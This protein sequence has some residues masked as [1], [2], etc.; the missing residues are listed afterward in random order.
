MN[1]DHQSTSQPSLERGESVEGVIRRVF[2][3]PRVV[4]QAALEDFAAQLCVLV[5]RAGHAERSL[6]VACGEVREAEGLIRGAVSG[7]REALLARASSTAEVSPPEPGSS[8]SVAGESSCDA[9]RAVT[10]AAE[11]GVVRIT[12]LSLQAEAATQFAAGQ[13]QR[14]EAATTSVDALRKALEEAEHRAAETAETLGT[15]M[16][17]AERRA[18]VVMT[19]LEAALA[20]FAR[21]TNE[22]MES[23]TTGSQ[24]GMNLP[25][26]EMVEL[27]ERAQR[28]SEALG[29]VTA[30]ADAVGSGLSALL[31]DAR[32]PEVRVIARS[33]PVARTDSCGS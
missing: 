33:L 5:E 21:R 13:A 4:D 23:G 2:L 17:E 1:H 32:L 26:A 31:K 7:I 24:R 3:T 14:L 11:E 29:R 16:S 27:V 19:G 12:A 20:D 6:R 30:R 18:G 28:V 15:A 10:R 25:V 22:V 8:S 9:V